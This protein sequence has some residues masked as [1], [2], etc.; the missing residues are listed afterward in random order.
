[1]NVVHM[2]AGIQCI[3]VDKKEPPAQ[4]R[5]GGEPCQ[6]DGRF[7]A[8]MYAGIQWMRLSV[9]RLRIQ[10]MRFPLSLDDD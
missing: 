4:L 7:V 9:T 5:T 6:G 10:W 8:P 2:S 3:G 1:M